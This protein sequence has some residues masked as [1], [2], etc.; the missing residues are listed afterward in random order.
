M[1]SSFPIGL[2]YN[3]NKILDDYKTSRAALSTPAEE[4]DPYDK[5]PP[6]DADIRSYSQSTSDT[7]YDSLQNARNIGT[8]IRGESRLNIVSA[9]TQNDLVDFYRFDVKTAGQLSISVTTDQSISIQVMRRDGTIIADSAMTSGEKAD[10]WQKLGTGELDL[11]AGSYYLKVTRDQSVSRDL[12][13]NYAIQLSMSRYFTKDYD[14]VESPA[15]ADVSVI[16]S[17]ATQNASA[18]NSVLNSL[19]NG[20]LFDMLL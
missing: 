5:D 20:S 12:K 18:L 9:L 19:G 11:T 17:V 14:T 3:V 7:V 4:A 1:T 15:S 2:N 6:R 8:L 16:S 13:P 10:N